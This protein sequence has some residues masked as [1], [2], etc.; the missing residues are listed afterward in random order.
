MAVTRIQRNSTNPQTTET[1]ARDHTTSKT[2]GNPDATPAKTQFDNPVA[3][4]ELVKG[5]QGGSQAST[6]SGQTNVYNNEQSTRHQ[7]DVKP[8]GEEAAQ[9]KGDHY[10]PSSSITR[11]KDTDTHQGDDRDHK[12]KR[13]GE[14]DSE[15]EEGEGEGGGERKRRRPRQP[16]AKRSGGAIPGAGSGVPAVTGGGGGGVPMLA[17]TGGGDGRRV[18]LGSLKGATVLDGQ[19]QDLFQPSLS[20]Q[21]TA[22]KTQERSIREQI[23]MYSLGAVGAAV[24][25]AVA[26]NADPNGENGM[27]PNMQK[28]LLNQSIEAMAEA[29]DILSVQYREIVREIVQGTLQA[30]KENDIQT[31]GAIKMLV[32]SLMAVSPHD[33]DPKMMCEALKVISSEILYGKLNMGYSMK[34]AAY[35]LGA[36]LFMLSIYYKNYQKRI[37]YTKQLEQ[38]LKYACNDGIWEAT[39]EVTG[40]S[41]EHARANTDRFVA[42]RIEEEKEFQRN[43]FKGIILMPLKK[44][45]NVPFIRKLL[46]KFQKGSI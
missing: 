2:S 34:L 6:P 15:E 42:G 46:S 27:G 36:A 24:F 9:F 20:T 21:S 12:V 28:V 41:E 35:A 16:G 39:G 31:Q 17:P 43:M 30:A 40:F 37:E 3:K 7:L 26:A 11:N 10:N 22:A 29:P 1:N 19:S 8:P 44:M 38:K 25:T 14:R 32:T 4:N 5:N 23:S 33:D 13:K 18:N 45:E